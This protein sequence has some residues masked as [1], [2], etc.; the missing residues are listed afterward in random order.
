MQTIYS[1]PQLQASLF[2]IFERYGIRKAILFGSYGKGRATEQSDIDLL[3]DSG[4]R[5]FRFTSFLE[6]VQQAVDK[7]VD[8]FDVTHIDAESLL[9]R[10]IHQTGV[11]FYEK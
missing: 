8:L 7:E 9:A 5:G 4:L 2:P 11:P 10:E 3:V 1:I 6:D